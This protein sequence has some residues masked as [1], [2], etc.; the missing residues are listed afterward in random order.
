MA[1][2]TDVRQLMQR[3]SFLENQRT[4]YEWTMQE[5]T[6][7]FMP[8]R[9]DITTRYSPGERRKPLFDSFGAVEADRF[10]NFLNGTL[11][12]SSSDWVK[13]RVRGAVEFSREIDAALYDTSMRVM[14]ALSASN[15]YVAAQ[16]DTRDW[17]VLGNSTLYVQHDDEYAG[18]N[19][20]FGGLNFDPVPFSRVW[21]VFS[22]IGRPLLLV[23]E[24]ERPAIDHVAFFNKPGDKIPPRMAQ[25]AKDQP[26][27]MVKVLHFIQRN[28]KGKK[29]GDIKPWDSRWVFKDDPFTIR[30]GQF[31]NCPYIAAR[32]MVMDGEQ[33]GRGRGH[34]ARP[35][36]KGVNEIARQK[37]IALGKEMNPPFMA[38][39]DEIAQLDLTP[40]G[41]VVVRPPKEVQP[42]YL[43][44]GTDFGLIEQVI[45]NMHMTVR[46]AFLGDALGEPEAQTRSAEA[47]RSRQARALARLASTSQTIVHE[48][49][50][51]LFENVTDIMLSKGALPELQ[52]I[53]NENPD[54]ELE[55]EFTSPFFTAMK[56]QSLA[57]IDS[58]LERRYQRFER[59][60]DPG[61][62][63]DIDNDQLREVEKFL[64]DVPA[65]I[66]RSQDEIEQLREARG[67]QAADD[68]IAQLMERAGQSQTQVQ[69]RPGGTRRNGA[70][71]AD[72]TGPVI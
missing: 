60:G 17:G 27:T 65:K 13:Y 64:G 44:S 71:L 5:I 57:R 63:E 14:D 42:G 69:L 12:P 26:F 53:I 24:L 4:N 40:G 59:T 46:E 72:M 67:D 30:R 35:I 6:D 21:W 45:A 34:L 20:E 61:A 38:E 54:L 22:C 62:L 36:M 70:G 29:G 18:D 48:K 55:F 51:P 52:A 19:D 31:N 11:Y 37:F 15:F 9:G 10:V 39:E 1:V 68:R 33:Y 25:L 7:L 58:F 23:R 56:A 49:L 66:F 32:M 47:E 43:R 50:S 28:E 16:T 3:F 2:T 41:H 8:Y